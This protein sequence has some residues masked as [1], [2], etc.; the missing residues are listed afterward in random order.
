M[1]QTRERN[2]VAAALEPGLRFMLY[3]AGWWLMLI[4]LLTCIEILGRKFFG[5]SLQGVDEIGGYTLG[6]TASM[7]FAYALVKRGHTRVDFLLSRMTPFWQSVCNVAAMVTL[8]ILV[9]YACLRGITVLSESIEFQSHS[10][11]PLRVPLWMPQSGWLFGWAVFAGT[12]VAFALHSIVL[13]VTDRRRLNAY[14]GPL[15][16]DEEIAAELGTNT[17]AP[18]PAEQESGRA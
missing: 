2:P 7:S 16:V 10:T 6:V 11:T 1:L 4:V 3:A 15:T 9:S 8:A 12:S 17:A 5:F 14:Y 18:R 13:F